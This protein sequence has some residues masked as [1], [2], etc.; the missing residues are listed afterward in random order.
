MF[1]QNKSNTDKKSELKFFRAA[2]IGINRTIYVAIAIIIIL[3]G[4]AMTGVYYEYW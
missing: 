3:A 4:I 1:I 2:R